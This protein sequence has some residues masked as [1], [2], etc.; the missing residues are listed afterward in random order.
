MIKNGRK[1]LLN[2]GLKFMNNCWDPGFGDSLGNLYKKKSIFGNFA[3]MSFLKH[4]VPSR[5]FF[6]GGFD[7]LEVLEQHI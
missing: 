5:A 6:G 7:D 2:P 3:P 1:W 4:T